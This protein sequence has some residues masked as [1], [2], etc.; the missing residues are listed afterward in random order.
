MKYLK[1]KAQLF[2]TL[3]KLEDVIQAERD[4]RYCK[5]LD[6]FYKDINRFMDAIDSKARH[7]YE[8]MLA[9]KEIRDACE[10]NPVEQQNSQ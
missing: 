10:Q 1:L 8:S 6:F 7:E 4:D 3:I 2:S 5:V 9:H